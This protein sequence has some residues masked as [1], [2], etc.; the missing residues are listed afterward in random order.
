MLEKE[1]S[2]TPVEATAKETYTKVRNSVIT[3]QSRIYSA[4]NTAMVQAYWE[5]G[6]QIYLACGENDRA[7]YGAGLLKYLSERLTTE[8]G[9]GFS[10]VA[11]EVQKLA[12]DMSV[13][14]QSIKSNLEELTKTITGLNQP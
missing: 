4:V 10:V 12:R 14:S 8:F 11:G 13:A 5:I 2:V 1:N 9:K 7:E 3:A 6:E